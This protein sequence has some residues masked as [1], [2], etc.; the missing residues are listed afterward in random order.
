MFHAA[1]AG[2][3]GITLDLGTPT[4]SARSS[5]WSPPPTSSSRT[6]AP[7]MDQFGLGWDRLHEVNPGL[8]MVRMPRSADRPWRGT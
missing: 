2:K 6:S 3:R 4:A 1:N 7:V 5:D 8:I